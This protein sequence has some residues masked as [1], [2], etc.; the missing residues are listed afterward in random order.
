MKKL[1]MKLTILLILMTSLSFADVPQLIN[2]QGKLTDAAGGPLTGSH[3]LSFSIYN[4]ATGGSNLWGPQNFANVGVTDGHFNVILGP[5]DTSSRSITSAFSGAAAYLQISVD[6]AAVLPRQQI[7]SAPYA[8]SAATIADHAVTIN[9]VKHKSHSSNLI[10]WT[11]SSVTP[12]Y[13]ATIQ[14]INIGGTEP[15]L[16][17][18]KRSGTVGGVPTPM[19]S[20]TGGGTYVT[21]A[22]RSCDLIILY[23]GVNSIMLQTGVTYFGSTTP[24]TITNFRLAITELF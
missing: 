18:V 14:T 10:N 15:K 20:I 8:I 6:G 12:T 2:Y 11:G 22:L 23:P 24:A 13:I 5:T 19:L 21:K 4:T 1:I 3:A 16:A 17:M 7:L 9:K